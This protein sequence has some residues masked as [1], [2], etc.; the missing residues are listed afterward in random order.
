MQL[1]DD[2]LLALYMVYDPEGVLLTDTPALDAVC[3]GSDLDSSRVLHDA[4]LSDLSQ[5]DTLLHFAPP[6]CAGTGYLSYMDLVQHL[7]HPDTF[8]YYMG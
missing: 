3:G 4:D 1:D 6:V 8:C 2:S 5:V 7:M